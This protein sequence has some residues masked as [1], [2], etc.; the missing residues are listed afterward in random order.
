MKVTCLLA[1]TLL[2]LPIA[3]L[4][5][6]D[7]PAQSSECAASGATY[8][9]CALWIDGQRVRRG[10]EGV[11][12]GR[13]GFFRP[14]RLTQ[15]VQGDSAV[16]YARGFERNTAKAGGFG[17]LSAAFVIAGFIVADSYDCNRDEFL[18]VCT[19]GD[20]D[21]TFTALGLLAGGLVSGIVS[22]VFQSHARRDA[23]RS[24]FWHNANFAR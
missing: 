1:A 5:G 8:V 7:A 9:R 4:A 12:V 15:L 22:G 18:G 14:L 6:Q 19:N 10:A 20:D 17:L 16:H 21:E 23:S 24:V 11:V 3:T 13:P 2:T